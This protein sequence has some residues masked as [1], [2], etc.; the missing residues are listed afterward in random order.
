MQT[1]GVE[2][3]GIYNVVGGIVTMFSFLNSAMITS[4]QRYMTFELGKE[5]FDRL[6]KVFSTSVNIH[7][8]IA[9][10][11]VILAETIGLWFLKEKMVIPTERE[12]AAM[13]VYQLSILTMVISMMS[14]PYNAIIV[15]HEK[16]S[17]FAYISVIEASLKLGI[18]YL[19]VYFGTD[20]LICYALLIACIQFIIRMVYV[21]YCKK[22]FVEANYSFIKDK[23]LFKEMF[24][25]AGWNLWG[26]IAS[27]LFGQGLNILLNM[28]FSPAVNAARAISVQVQNAI[29][30]FSY[31]FQLALNPQIT[32]SYATNEL[33]KMHNLI[34]RSS[35]FT[36]ML[37]LILC[38]PIL[39]EAQFILKIWLGTVPDYTEIFLKIMIITMI[40]DSSSNSLM[41]SAAA[42]GNVKKYQSAIGGILLTIVPISYVV[43]K[44]GAP[45][46]S[47][48]VVHLIICCVA[49]VTRLFIV[50]P[51][52]NLKIHSFLK[53]VIVRCFFVAIASSILPITIKHFII[54]SEINSIVLIITSVCSATVC[55]VLLGLS[56]GE[57][58]FILTKLI[59]VKQR[60]FNK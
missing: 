50:K 14:S 1:L 40:I 3:F 19:L 37:L 23:K 53:I 41:V 48:F 10:L 36:F 39:L 21:A 56:H 42:T 47:V 33:D 52:I 6:K 59:S 46:W 54:E 58:E 29:F 24:S 13:W 44:M 8:L 30:Q 2:D 22:H 25:F 18:V 43:L 27:I 31:N 20:K 4:S 45:P 11:V 51:M 57:R 12:T 55:S 28:F 9:I 32:K 38:L 5:N 35:K 17:A 16:M 49:F 34:Y 26:N 60:F 7:L 15:A